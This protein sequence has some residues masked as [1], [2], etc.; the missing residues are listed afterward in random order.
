MPTINIGGLELQTDR[1]VWPDGK[2]SFADAKEAFEGAF[3][4]RY[5]DENDWNISRT[6]AAIGVERSQLH[7]K[8]KALDIHRDDMQGH[9]D[10]G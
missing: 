4:R 8:M 9:G 10:N 1:K 2:A 3:L 7:R 6:A 5:L